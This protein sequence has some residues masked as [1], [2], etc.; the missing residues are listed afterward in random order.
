MLTGAASVAPLDRE[1]RLPSKTHRRRAGNAALVLWLKGALQG[2]NGAQYKARCSAPMVTCCF[3]LH[4]AVEIQ[5]LLN[6]VSS[7]LCLA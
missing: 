4:A 7:T 3:M 2:R 5:I 1:L 6:Y